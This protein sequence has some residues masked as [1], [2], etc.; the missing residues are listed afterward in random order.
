MW[1]YIYPDVIVI[2]YCGTN[3]TDNIGLVLIRAGVNVCHCE[4]KQQDQCVWNGK[5]GLS[6]VRA[7]FA[8]CIYSVLALTTRVYFVST[9]V[10]WHHP[11][12]E[13][14]TYSSE[15]KETFAHTCA[16]AHRWCHPC[17]LAV[18]WQCVCLAPIKNDISGDITFGFLPGYFHLQH[19]QTH[20]LSF[21][22]SCIITMRFGNYVSTALWKIRRAYISTPVFF[23]LW[24]MKEI[25][26]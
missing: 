20:T 12:T 24:K 3:I 14:W 23:E 11:G 22:L 10:T 6:C 1:L 25:H 19:T 5:T 18:K 2:F 4:T 16:P 21:S 7:L 9:A 13:Q 17:S 8:H 26:I 15:G